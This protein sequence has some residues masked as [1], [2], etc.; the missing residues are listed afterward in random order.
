MGLP[1]VKKNLGVHLLGGKFNGFLLLKG[2]GNVNYASIIK[3][4]FMSEK[5]H[6][7]EYT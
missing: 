3:H 5:T 1:G 6:V 4:S 7:F 2:G